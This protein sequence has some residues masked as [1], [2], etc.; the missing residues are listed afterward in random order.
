MLSHL[1]SNRSYK[2]SVSKRALQN[3][4]QL[5][6]KQTNGYLDYKSGHQSFRRINS[7]YPNYED[8]DEEEE[9]YNED[10]D[11]FDDDDDDDYYHEYSESTPFRVAMNNKQSTANTSYGSFGG[12]GG[13]RAWKGNAHPIYNTSTSNSGSR[14]YSPHNYKRYGNGAD[15]NN[16][17][18]QRIRFTL[19]MILII[20][21]IL[22]LGFV[23]GFLLA[24]TKPL[25]NVAIAD[26]FDILVSDEELMFDVVVEGINPGFLSVEISN[27]DLDVF[28]R[29]A[30]VQDDKNSKD[31]GEPHT[32][33]LGNI[34]H[35]EVPLSFDGGV[36]SRRLL[37]SVG[38]FRLVHPGRNT[39][40]SPNDDNDD[41][42]D[43]GVLPTENNSNSPSGGSGGGG[44]GGDI[45]NG[46][47]KWARVS[48]H[49]FE[50]IIRGVLKY[51]LLLSNN[52]MASISKVSIILL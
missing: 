48:L 9:F 26:M 39:T 32:M 42:V 33:L 23:M 18:F 29:S 30:Y 51:D 20:L 8:G 12:P 40:S 21:S 4:S 35:F 6:S 22:G 25:H 28:A 47:K 7:R 41:D 36:L 10:D 49:P 13:R 14:A 34:Q 17:R 16:V 43:L 3:S 44:N 38:Q 11:D 24:T 45:D 52:K 19:W 5:R 37:K 31:K 27:V 46:Q 50:L 1:K 15:G 2:L